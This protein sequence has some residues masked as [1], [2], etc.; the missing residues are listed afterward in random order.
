MSGDP[1][2]KPQQVVLENIVN[3][4]HEHVASLTPTEMTF[5]VAPVGQSWLVSDRPYVNDQRLP[6]RLVV[7]AN[8]ILLAYRHSTFLRYQ[9]QEAN[10]SFLTEVNKQITLQARDWLAAD[11]AATLQ[12]YGSLIHSPV[13]HKSVAADKP[14][15][16]PVRNLRRGWAINS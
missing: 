16:Q 15:I 14:Y 3:Q 6:V 2:R 4:V 1:K 5:Y 12:A 8:Q 10:A 13:W 9:Y 11:S 7:L